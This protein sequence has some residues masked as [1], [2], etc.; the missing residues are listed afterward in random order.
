VPVYET[1]GV[2]WERRDTAPPAVAALRMDVAAF[3]GMARRGPLDTAVAVESFRQFEAHFGGCIG[4]GYLAYAL[5]AF[6]DN[7]GRRAFVVRVAA[8]DGAGAAASAA[9]EVALPPL[10]GLPEAPLGWRIAASSPGAWGNALDV[11]VRPGTRVAS[12]TEP[13]GSTAVALRISNMAGFDRDALVRLSQPGS[14]VVLRIVAAVEAGARLLHLVHPNPA[15]RRPQDLPLTG[16]DPTLPIL[17]EAL[18]WTLIVRESGRLVGMAADLSPVPGHPRHA[19]GILAA[20]DYAAA[21]LQPVPLAAPFPVVVRPILDAASPGTLLLA[22]T[23]G[24]GFRLDGGRDGLAALGVADFLGEPFAPED[25]PAAPRRGL[26]VLE[27]LEEPAVLAVPDICIRPVAAPDIEP[28]ALL[29]PDP[30]APCPLP[31]EPAPLRAPPPSELPRAFD[32]E[33][34]FRVQQALVEQCERRR[35][36][37]ALLDPPFGA[38]AGNAQG[39]AALEAWRRRFDSRHAALYAP[40]VEVLD[41]LRP[42]ELRPVPPAGHVAGQYALAEALEG[43][44]RAPANR[45][46]TW[47]EAVTMRIGEAAHG[48]L[49]GLGVNV[50]RP[51]LGRALRILGARTVSSDPAARFVPVRRLVM[52]LIRS[53]DRGT[54]WAVFEPNDQATRAA[55]AMS[56]E[57]FLGRLWAAGALAGRQPD[58]AFAVRC[59]ETNNP[60]DARA[61]GRLVCDVAVAPVEPLEFVVLRIGRVGGELEIEERSVALRQEVAA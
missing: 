5:K 45:D 50:I 22:P 61:N 52:L 7:G 18:S 9:I 29:R 8:R 12:D 60:P 38:V 20:P 54:R 55:V 19:P 37:I 44:H 31:A 6:F 25:G 56:L 35:D 48:L 14:P 15:R 2:Y 58:A 40:W 21:A 59:D 51:S 4:G 11:A 39:L 57:G 32:D 30:C 1:P 43:V 47:A 10:P 53:F 34:I 23:T 3:V 24:A 13:A 26:Q 42:H 36:R 33:E 16:L 46:L 17:V 41:P 49:N 27:R 28:P